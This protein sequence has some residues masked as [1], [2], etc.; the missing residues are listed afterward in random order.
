M[1]TNLEELLSLGSSVPVQDDMYTMLELFMCQ[2]YS[3]LTQVTTA[4]KLRWFL[5]SKKQCA[6]EKMPPTRAALQQ[7]KI[8][9]A[10]YVSDIKQGQANFSAVKTNL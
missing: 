1:N 10:N 8:K 6:D 5:F 9:R 3:P 4:K 2:L 7:I